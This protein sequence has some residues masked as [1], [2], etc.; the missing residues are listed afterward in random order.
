MRMVGKLENVF[1]ELSKTLYFEFQTIEELTTYFMEDHHDKL[2]HILGLFKREA[3]E[4][5][6]ENHFEE[7]FSISKKQRVRFEK[8]DQ[9]HDDVA[10]IGLSGRYPQ[11]ENLD[12]F[13]EVLKSGRDCIT[14]IP[15][16][17]WD[18]MKYYDPDKKAGKTYSKWGGFISDFDKFDSLFFNISP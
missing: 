18:F 3:T 16:E 10:I 11:A 8:T 15:A 7:Q 6:E 9:R 2:I 13:W 5:S 17:R 14:E 12:E 1:G 4:T